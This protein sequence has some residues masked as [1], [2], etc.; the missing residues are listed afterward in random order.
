M[1]AIPAASAGTSSRTGPAVPVVCRAGGGPGPA[2]GPGRAGVRVR[3]AQ[4]VS[5]C[6]TSTL[7]DQSK[8]VQGW[9]SNQ[10]TILACLVELTAS[11]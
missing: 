2:R 8:I 9:P 5:S 6:A 7:K 10:A 1:K 3:V 11:H 4:L